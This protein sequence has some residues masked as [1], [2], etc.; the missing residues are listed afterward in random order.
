MRDLFIESLATSFNYFT[1]C[2][3]TAPVS[4]GLNYQF[5]VNR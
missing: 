1:M 5:K 3:G 2:R 4:N